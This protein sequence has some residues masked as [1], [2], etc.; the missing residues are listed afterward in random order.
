M[1]VLRVSIEADITLPHEAFAKIDAIQALRPQIEAIGAFANESTGVAFKVSAVETKVV[2]RRPKE[3]VLV[4][5]L[6]DKISA[7]KTIDELDAL[8][9]ANSDK[10]GALGEDIK[11]RLYEAAQ[12]AEIKLGGRAAA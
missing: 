1:P 10:V 11:G 4:E 9:A 8:M 3:E 6:S 5:K 12:A 7:V 2:V